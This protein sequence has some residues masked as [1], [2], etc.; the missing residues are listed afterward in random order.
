M[1][2]KV[3]ASDMDGTFLREDHSFDKERFGRLLD[4]FEDRDYL[5]VAA[6]GRSYPSLKQVFAGFEHRIAFVAEN[7]AVV[8]YQDELIFMDNP[9]PSSV[10]LRLIEELVA[11]GIVEAHHVTLSSLSGSYMLEAVED[12]LLRD[13]SGYYQD[14]RLIAS[15]EQ[16]T[17]E[18][19]KLNIYV[20]EEKRQQAQDWINQH[21]GNLSAVTTGFTSI[22]IILSGVHKAVGLG[23]L[24]QHLRLTAEDVTAFGDNQ[25]D[26]EMLEFAGLAIATENARPEVKA[27]ADKVIGHCN[28]DAVL[29][30][31]GEVVYGN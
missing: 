3:F 24:C 18:V 4:A 25:N 2:K 8:S 31:L 11:S 23:H 20:A 10:Y 15:F 29:T 14:I 19:I 30:Y 17:E 9:I 27:V 21:F 1:I 13:L 6:S 7:G 16:V 28:D 22:D 5:F 26:L 12:D